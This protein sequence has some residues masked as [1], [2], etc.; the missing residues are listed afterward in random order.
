MN[1]WRCWRSWLSWGWRSGDQMAPGRWCH[2]GSEDNKVHA[3]KARG[4]CHTCDTGRDVDIRT[5]AVLIAG[6]QAMRRRLLNPWPISTGLP[7][8]TPRESYSI[9]LPSV[10]SPTRSGVGEPAMFPGENAN[11]N[12]DHP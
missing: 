7:H 1:V 8:Q 2:H 12:D 11:V 3:G 4:L 5:G 9:T 6:G 10:R